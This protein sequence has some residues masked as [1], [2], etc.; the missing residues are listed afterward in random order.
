[1][2]AWAVARVKDE[3]DIIA[4][5]I[6]WTLKQVDWVIAEDNG[7]VDGTRGILESLAADNP[8][9]IVQDDPD[10]GYYQSAS[11]SRL[12]NQA[13]EAGAT[14][15]LPVDADEIHVCPGGHIATALAA[16]DDDVLVSEAPLYDHVATGADSDDADPIQRLTYRRAAQAPLRKVAVR[17]VEGVT[18][19]QGNHSA[20]FPGVRHP[21]TVTD[22]MCVHH[23]PY[24][25]VEQFVSKVR[26]GAAAYAATDL[27][28]EA[29][30]HWRQYG[31]ILEAQGEAGIAEIFNTWFYRENPHE[32]LVIHGEQQR[33]LINDPCPR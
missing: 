7:S 23:F 11:M 14:W 29:G 10:V 24:R 9:L 21:K 27:P 16:L 2:S 32:E 31:A 5:T 8:R 3:A 28:P 12:A 18:I 19:H 22:L 15:V 6:L 25:S 4:S 17:A 1:M 33:A 30:A 13:R 20:S 26:N